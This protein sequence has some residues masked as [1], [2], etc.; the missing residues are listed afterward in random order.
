MSEA[1]VYV[2]IVAGGT[3]ARMGTDKP[4]QFLHLAGI[5]VL[6]YTL[7][8]F[9]AALPDA[10]MVLAV[11][12]DWMD[13][14]HTI[15]NELPFSS[16]VELTPGGKTRF[17]SVQKALE[18]IPNKEGAMVAIHDAVRPLVTEELIIR[19]LQK[20][21][22]T[23]AALPVIGLRDSIRKIT[24]PSTSEP[25]DRKPLRRAQTPQCFELIGLKEAYERPYEDAYTDDASVWEAA[26][27]QMHWIEGRVDNLKITTP[28]DLAVAEVLLNRQED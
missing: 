17:H 15:V 5:P 19:T 3:G 18:R 28:E 4:K 14:A 6:A 27:G 23:G 26:G 8:R 11:H 7:M 21:K 25:V 22:E 1:P 9:N 16:Q 13:E 10:P 12:P 2:I 24:G 20:A